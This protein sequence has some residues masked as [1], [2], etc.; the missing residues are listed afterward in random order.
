MG[1][2]KENIDLNWVVEWWWEIIQN[3][4]ATGCQSERVQVDDT[5]CT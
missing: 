2:A 1:E 4:G 5:E 3:W